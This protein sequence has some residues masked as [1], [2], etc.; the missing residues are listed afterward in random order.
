M[1]ILVTERAQGHPVLQGANGPKGEKGESA[2]DKLQESLVR[3]LLKVSA[4]GWLGP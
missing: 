3:G 2:S 1:A 4:E